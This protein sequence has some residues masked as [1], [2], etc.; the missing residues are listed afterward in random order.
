MAKFDKTLRDII[1]NIPQKFVSTLTGKKG[2]KIL[3]NTFPSTKERV[4][5]LVLQLEDGSVF[6]LEL[7][8]QNDKNMP[9][10]MLECYLLLKQR[11]PDNPVKQMVLYV[12][13]GRPNMP[14][15]LETDNLRFSYEI[16][17]IKDIECKELLESDSLEDKILAVLCKVEDFERYIFELTKE[18]LKLPEKQRA[19]YIRKLLIALN[20]RPKLK[21]KL[22]TLMEEKK[23]PLVITEEMAKQDPFYDLGYKKGKEEGKEEA[24]KEIAKNM[25]FE[26]KMP[27]EQIAK[28]LKVP[29]EFV[30]K[31]IKEKDEL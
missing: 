22:K 25:Y 2:T 23:M 10:R 6:H 9:F 11:Y 3:D 28:V 8:T 18:L 30:E 31:V 19:D 16:R 5:D 13:D 21:M 20:Y 24:K 27:I 17:D 15:S 7:Q 14:S 12:G 26:L 1:Q 4:A 29:T